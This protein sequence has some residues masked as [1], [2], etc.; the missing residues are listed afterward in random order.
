M[1]LIGAFCDLLEHAVPKKRAHLFN[2]SVVNFYS[3][4]L[5]GTST[6]K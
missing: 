3:H 2:H 6:F 4:G 5:C 1:K